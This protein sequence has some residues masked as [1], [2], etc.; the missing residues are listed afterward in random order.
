MMKYFIVSSRGV[1]ARKKIVTAKQ[2]K[3]IVCHHHY[4][5]DRISP[6]PPLSLIHISFHYCHMYFDFF[7]GV[8]S[9]CSIQW[10]VSYHMFPLS[11]T[12]FY[13][14]YT[15]AVFCNHDTK[16]CLDESTPST[17]PPFLKIYLCT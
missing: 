14:W 9:N 13:F 17:T 5:M 7:R 12:T 4:F 11:Y 10:N 3:L 15:C 1:I 6:V 16:G 2:H 8:L